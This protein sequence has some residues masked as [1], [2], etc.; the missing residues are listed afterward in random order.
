MKRLSA[1]G[2]HV[3]SLVM[4]RSGAVPMTAPPPSIPLADLSAALQARMTSP[5]TKKC[6]ADSPNASLSDAQP[7]C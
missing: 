6:L 4:M 3:G 7:Q 1:T 5:I 2:C